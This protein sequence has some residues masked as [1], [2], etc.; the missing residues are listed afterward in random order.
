MK[1]IQNINF[2]GI[3]LLYNNNVRMCACMQFFYSEKCTFGKNIFHVHIIYT[4]G[5]NIFHV[6]IMIWT[7]VAIIIYVGWYME[8]I[9]LGEMNQW[10][11]NTIQHTIN[12]SKGQNIKFHYKMTQIFDCVEVL[13]FDCCPVG[14]CELESPSGLST[15]GVL[16][17]I[18]VILR[19]LLPSL[20]MRVRVV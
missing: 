8:M 3:S 17:I 20:T 16:G 13:A 15:T 12:F 18:S 6:H 2:T 10:V 14:G 19:F 11:M 1:T 9:F 5:K 4:F 7:D